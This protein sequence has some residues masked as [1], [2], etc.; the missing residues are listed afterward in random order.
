MAFEEMAAELRQ[1]AE[2]ADWP[3]VKCETIIPFVRASY[4]TLD[5]RALLPVEKG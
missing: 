2:C 5:L 4:P 3:K 1:C